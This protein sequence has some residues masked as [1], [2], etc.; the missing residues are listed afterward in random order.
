MKLTAI[1]I[2]LCVVNS[3]AQPGKSRINNSRLTEN[4]TQQMAQ[5]NYLQAADIWRGVVDSDPTNNNARWNLA[6]CYMQGHNYRSAAQ[7]L[8]VLFEST[9][10]DVRLQ[11]PNTAYYYGVMLKQI[12]NPE[13]AKTVLNTFITRNKVNTD[14][15]TVALITL[16]TAERN[17]CD[18]EAANY[19][20]LKAEAVNMG[21]TMNGVYTECAPAYIDDNTMLLGALRS[22]APILV[23]D[24]AK[25]FA[26]IYT[27]NRPAGVVWSQPIALPDAVNAPNTNNGNAVMS[28]D[29][30]R[31]YF[32]RCTPDVTGKQRCDIYISNRADNGSYSAT[33][34]LE[35]EVN[36]P[37]SSSSMPFVLDAGRGD[38][39][40]YFSSNR[41]NGKGGY[42]L[43]KVI[44]HPEGTYDGFINLAE[45]QYRRRRTLALW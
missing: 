4:A 21:K 44:R 26:K 41:K 27:A 30:K 12:G 34:K 45:C 43:Y 7:E 40:L 19:E 15:V 42:D 38:D 25:A 23:K 13:T 31:L 36:A 1:V 3:F 2:L 35:E 37:N 5:G 29:G 32:T 16:A 24:A 39:L 9:D 33:V 20:N 6:N 18:M 11:Y 14:A 8:K 10:A 17:G 28:A 22:D